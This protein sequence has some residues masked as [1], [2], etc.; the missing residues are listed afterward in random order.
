MR[1][2]RRHTEDAA[3]GRALDATYAGSLGALVVVLA[4]AAWLAVQV[5]PAV[6]PPGAA[7]TR[8]VRVP[9]GPVV[10]ESIDGPVTVRVRTLEV[11]RAEV[12]VASYRA[13][14]AAGKCSPPS[15]PR[16]AGGECHH[17]DPE[18]LGS[19]MSCVSVK[20]A[21]DYCQWQDAR[22]PTASEWRYLAFG[23]AGAEAGLRDVAGGLEE[24]ACDVAPE[25][26]EVDDVVCWT[27]A[28]MGGSGAPEAAGDADSLEGAAR[29]RK[30]GHAWRDGHRSVSTG[31]RCV[32]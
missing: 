31:F 4:A 30:T 20:E 1:P 22:L 16:D 24:W 28:K 18:R 14:V 25:A 32:R 23:A 27:F 8:M 19:P 5:M 10:V 15:A 26:E 3:S 9:G 17:E 21:I 12:S 6:V 7:A 2:S 13:C 11:D 29:S